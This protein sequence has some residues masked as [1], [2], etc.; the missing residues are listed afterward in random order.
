MASFNRVLIIGNLGR[1]PELRYTPS[2]TAICS[3]NIAT[4]EAWTDK[5]GARQEKTEWH[6]V[7]VWGKQGEQVSKY[8]KKGSQVFVEGSLTTSSWDDAKTGQKR[9]KTEIK[10]QR[11][12]FL[13]RRGEAPAESPMDGGAPFEGDDTKFADDDIPF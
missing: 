3:L 11:V 9:Y 2:Q 13:D 7:V 10:A 12:Q 5:S 6:R 8:L 4:N 1:D